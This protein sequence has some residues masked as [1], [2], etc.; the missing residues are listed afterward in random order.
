MKQIFEGQVFEALPT[1]NGII[2]SY[3]RE[4][5]EEDVIVAYKML[6]F[7][8]GRFTDVAKNIYMITKF[9]NNYKAV[10]AYCK[11]Y[12]SS[13][14]LMLPNG[15]V[16]LLEPDGGA[17]LL[18][19]EATPI[20]SGSLVYKN[21]APSDIVLYGNAIWAAYAESDVLLRYNPA[22]MREEL[23]IGGN[24]SP[25]REPSDLFL[26]GN[27]VVVSNKGSK[28]LIKINLNTYSVSDFYEF[29]E[30]VYQYICVDNR[31]FAVLESGLYLL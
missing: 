21:N 15:K 14:V 22:T 29:D 13:K 31:D 25:F 27:E 20:W 2:F 10:A 5:R 24:K 3:C 7:E 16:F 1:S 9:G 4:I 11:N 19:D 8:N 23:R 28:K 17:M 26:M 18:N 6:S 30:P 12:I